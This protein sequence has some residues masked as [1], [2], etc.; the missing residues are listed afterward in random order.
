MEENTN[1]Y[2]T[3]K[4]LS[5]NYNYLDIGQDFKQEILDESKSTIK[6]LTNCELN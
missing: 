5:L 2:G 6:K 4:K 1:Q 3:P